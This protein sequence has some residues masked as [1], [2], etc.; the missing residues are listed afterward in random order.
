MNKNGLRTICLA[1]CDI[2]SGFNMEGVDAHGNP[3]VESTNLTCV[4]IIGIKDPVRLE[5]PKAVQECKSA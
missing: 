2:P 4:C 5:V 1:Y 3:A